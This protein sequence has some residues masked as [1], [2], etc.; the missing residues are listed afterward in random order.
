MRNFVFISLCLLSLL[1]KAQSEIQIEVIVLIHFQDTRSEDLRSCL[2]KNYLLEIVVEDSLYRSI[3]FE[4]KIEELAPIHLFV[5]QTYTLKII[6]L[7]DSTCIGTEELSTQNIKEHTRIIREF[8]L[9]TLHSSL[10]NPMPSLYFIAD[11]V[12]ALNPENMLILNQL[13]EFMKKY[14]HG[15]IGIYFNPNFENSE[16][17]NL[18]RYFLILNYANKMGVESERFIFVQDADDL[19]IHEAR[20]LV[21]RAGIDVELYPNDGII[22]QT[23]YKK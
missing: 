19:E 4:A 11:E 15:Q 7:S 9:F 16:R 17:V 6:Q 18:Q 1:S 8:R 14:C 23:I 12:E 5:N 21:Y 10:K 3:P 20:F 13:F 22:E 2:D